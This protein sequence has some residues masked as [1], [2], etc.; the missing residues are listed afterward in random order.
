MMLDRDG[1]DGGNVSTLAIAL[2]N[3]D[4]TIHSRKHS[5]SYDQGHGH[6]LP[7]ML[8]NGMNFSCASSHT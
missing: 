6:R 3:F 7:E 2:I 8:L 5:A 4:F 1:G